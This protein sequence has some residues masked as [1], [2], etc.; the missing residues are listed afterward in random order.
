MSH[1]YQFILFHT[2]CQDLPSN[3]SPLTLDGQHQALYSSLSI[4][5]SCQKAIPTG[6]DAELKSTY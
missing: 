5:Q 4:H 3:R 6:H 2:V 1:G